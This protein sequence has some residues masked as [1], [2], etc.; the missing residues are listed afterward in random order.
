ML[1]KWFEEFRTDIALT[2]QKTEAAVRRNRINRDNAYDG[3][4]LASGRDLDLFA[5]ERT[6][7]QLGKVRLGFKHCG[8]VHNANLL[9][10]LS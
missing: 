10:N 7:N 1:R 3:L 8:F 4:A 9:S 6:L 5:I 2:L